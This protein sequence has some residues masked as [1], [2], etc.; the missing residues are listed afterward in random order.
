MID[1]QCGVGLRRRP[2]AGAWKGAD[3]P[4]GG[5][6]GGGCAPAGA[7]A[8]ISMEGQPKAALPLSYAIAEGR[9]SPPFYMIFM[10]FLL[11]RGRGVE[12]NAGVSVFLY[13]FFG[14]LGAGVEE[15][16]GVAIFLYTFWAKTSE[17][18]EENEGV[19]I[20]LYTFFEKMGKNVE[21][22]EGVTIFLYTFREKAVFGV[23][24]N[25]GMTI[26]LPF[27]DKNVIFTVEENQGVP[28]F[29]YTFAQ[30]HQRTAK[31]RSWPAAS[32]RI[33]CGVGLR[34]TDWNQAEAPP[35]RGASLWKD[36]RKEVGLGP[37]SSLFVFYMEG[38][39][40]PP[41]Y[42]IFMVFRLGWRQL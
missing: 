28:V 3:A 1:R 39:R 10:G 29:L 13:T 24:E 8:C 42:L 2:E 25:R 6:E 16:E 32:D 31:K 35:S 5:L 36:K 15:N 26:F 33:R 12:E 38:R 17:S 18:V 22:N 30:N 7:L 4:G 23:E 9:R 40:S 19:A 14:K 41:F 20:F 27:F 37:T 34:P 21:E 11:W